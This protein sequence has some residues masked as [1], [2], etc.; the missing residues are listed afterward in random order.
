[1]SGDGWRERCQWGEAV[2]ISR[3]FYSKELFP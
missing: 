2:A 1:V 3:F